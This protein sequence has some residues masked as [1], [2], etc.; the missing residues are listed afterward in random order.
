M[1]AANDVVVIAAPER[2]REPFVRDLIDQRVLDV[3][4][5]PIVALDGATVY[6]HEALVRTPVGC[7]WTN[8]DALFA[9]A[10]A[11][12]ISI[13]LEIE[14]VR[15][16]LERWSARS[17]SGK[18]FIN[19]SASALLAAIGTRGLQQTLQLIRSLGVATASI[20]IELTEHEHVRDVEMLK[21]A[22]AVLRRYGICVALDDFGDGRSSLRLWSELK[23][24]I[25][26]IDKYFTRD[27]ATSGDKLQTMRALLQI[28]DTF[29]SSLVAEG[30]ETADELRVVRDL[31]I[32][33]GQGYYLGRPAALPVETPLRDAHEVLLAREI[34]VFPE[35]QRVGHGTVTAERM[36]L[37]APTLPVD[38]THGEALALF[39]RHPELRAVAI[40]DGDRPVALVNRHD[41]VLSFAKPYFRELY[42]RRPALMHANRTPL[43]LDI[44]TK[45]DDLTAVLTSSDQRYLTEGFVL[46]EAGRYRGLGTGEQLVRAVTETRIEAARHAN[47]LTFL[48]G[49]IPTTVHIERLLASGKPFHA[50]YGDLNHFKPFNDQYGYWRGDEMIL[51]AA[52]ILSSHCDPQ[53][54]FLGHVGGDDFIVL[55]Q[56]ADWE[57]RCLQIV[58]TFN[59]RAHSLFDDDALE[60]GGIQAEDRHGVMRFHP[61]TTLC[62]G[63]VEASP[64]RYPRPEDVASAAAVAKRHAKAHDLALYRLT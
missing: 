15:I 29:G 64:Q 6:G 59:R 57:A 11:E 46:T 20:V 19:L 60:A 54:D 47:S 1:I 4:F 35:R 49:N 16:A 31:G 50:C 42:E 8:P 61:L 14:C 53:L 52:R 30:V 62:I 2:F 44:H 3:H 38:G 58:E 22:T 9:A 41:F 40:V 32:R 24:E 34:A 5:Q 26:K 23:P 13:E 51:L 56:S 18:L 17:V 28:A 37:Q 7:H 10:R 39:E 36:L 45:L 63:A 27:L 21:T 12:E 48:P 43:Q 25:V 33:F 55:F